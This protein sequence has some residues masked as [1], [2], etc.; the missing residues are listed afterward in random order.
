MLWNN[1][2]IGKLRKAIEV[3]NRDVD[4][5]K[6]QHHYDYVPSKLE[7]QETMKQIHTQEEYEMTL[8]DIKDIQRRRNPEAWTP[9]DYHGRIIPKYMQ[10][11]IE[12]QQQRINVGNESVRSKIYPEWDNMTPQEQAVAYANGNLMDIQGEYYSNEDLDDLISQYYSTTA[13]TYFDNYLSAWEEHCVLNSSLKRKVI[14]IIQ[15]FQSNRL[16]ALREIFDGYRIEK[17]IEYI[18]PGSAVFADLKE[19]HDNVLAFWEE[20]QEQYL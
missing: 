14:E 13:S 5:M 1:E 10:E 11:Q 9:V 15:W 2:T 12:K 7:L 20:M 6:R 8:Y 3:F 16:D 17:E 19:R 4:R 18:Y